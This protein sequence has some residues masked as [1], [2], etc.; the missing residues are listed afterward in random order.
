MSK[1]KKTEQQIINESKSTYLRFVITKKLP[2]TV[3]I[4]VKNKDYDS[5]YLGR[6]Y[7]YSKWRCYVIEPETLTIFEKKCLRD[8][9]DL[10]DKL[11]A[12]QKIKG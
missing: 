11:T 9:A 8:I 2:K 12:N 6:I 10:I 4:V 5:S 1:Q 3:V 7:W